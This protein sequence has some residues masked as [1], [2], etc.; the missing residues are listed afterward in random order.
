M[1]IEHELEIPTEEPPARKISYNSDVIK[2]L[3]EFVEFNK[4]DV[5]L[6]IIRKNNQIYLQKIKVNVLK[7]SEKI[8]QINLT[9]DD[10]FYIEKNLAYLKTLQAPR[11]N[12]DI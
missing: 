8:E 1:S 3:Y 4:Y 6:Q 9:A 7:H 12:E 11:L 10:L 5:R 2:L